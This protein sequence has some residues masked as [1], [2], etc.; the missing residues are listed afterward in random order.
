MIL[1]R[2][3]ANKRHLIDILFVLSLFCIFAFSSIALIMFGSQIYKNTLKN[4]DY[5]FNSRTCS[6]YLTEK[7]RQADEAD[8]IEILQTES[9]TILML[10]TQIDNL[11]YV[12]ALYEYDH[13]L[14]ELFARTDIPLPLDAGQELM[15][16]SDLQ[17]SFITS[18]ILKISYTDATGISNTLYVST[19]SSHTE[20]T[21][22]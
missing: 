1:L 9:Q 2:F 3:E 15:E 4:M 16:I 22:E 19:H 18:C 14:Y 6:S 17:F 8:S 12:T 20:D 13:H 10:H 21:Y 7:I 5:N 11:E